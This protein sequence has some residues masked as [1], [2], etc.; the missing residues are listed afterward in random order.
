MPLLE[1]MT[2]EAI[3]EFC[4]SLPHA[5]EQVQWGGMLVFK[6]AGKKMFCLLNL[7]PER[8]DA[9]VFFKASEEEF[10]ALQENEGVIPA[11]YMAR[12]KWLALEGWDALPMP[13][14][15]RLLK[16]SYELVFAKLP[17]RTQAGLQGQRPLRRAR[18]RA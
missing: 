7:E 10:L 4:M 6:I 5:T 15:K 13:E 18:R 12:A 9:L 3:R 1:P 14:L 16:K 11:P 8:D 2:V 17:K